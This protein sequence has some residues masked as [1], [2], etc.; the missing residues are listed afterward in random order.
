MWDVTLPPG[1]KSPPFPLEA[2]LV[3]DEKEVEV[4]EKHPVEDGALRMARTV[5]SR[6]IGNPL[7]KSVPGMAEAKPRLYQPCLGV[8]DLGQAG[9]GILPE[10]RRLPF[11]WCLP[12]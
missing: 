5:D 10:T 4:M 8:R 1:K 7:S 2:P 11:L 3:L 6:H 12:S 9:I